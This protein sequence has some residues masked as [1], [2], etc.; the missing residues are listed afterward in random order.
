LNINGV[1]KKRKTREI[2]IDLTHFGNI[3]EATQART[4]SDEERKVLRDAQEV[5]ARLVPNPNN[6]TSAAVLGGQEDPESREPK[7]G[8]PG[9]RS[10][11]DFV[12]PDVVENKHRELKAGQVCP[13]GCGRLYALKRPLHHR[14][15]TGQA[16][17]K[18]TLFESEQL[19]CSTCGTVYTAPLPDGVGPDSYAPSAKSTIAYAKYGLG[20]PF[21]RQAMQYAALGVPISASVLWEAVSSA[22]DV[23]QPVYEHL[24]Q[25]AAEGEVGFFDD[26]SMPILNFDRKANDTRTGLFTTGIVSTRG[27]V[28]V[29][30]FVTGRDHAGEN[31]ATLLAKRPPELA[32]MIQMSDA[33][34]ANTAYVSSD[35]L[36]AFCLAHG[37]R[38]FVKIIE[39]FPAEC[40]HVIRTIGTVYHHDSLSREAGHTPEERL[41][42]H[43][44]L[45]G[46]VMDTLKFWLDGQ[47]AARKTEPNSNLGKAI[48]YLRKH[49]EGLTLFLRQPGA[50]LDSNAVE[51]ILKKVVLFRKNSLFYKTAR[52]ARV[53]DIYLSLI[54]T[55][56]L[57]RANPHQY[58]TVLQHHIEAFKAAPADWMPWNFR[59]A[60]DRIRDPAATT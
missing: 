36:I 39:S 14:H 26:T 58:L 30:I 5:L 32:K 50:P 46:P 53:G 23:L 1:G 18:V 45:S 37:R 28:Q 11:S 10:R 13:C 15:F 27:D 38:N 25:V 41:A 22:A 24:M 16:A 59:E 43:K 49:W 47:I 21:H 52:G 3:V 20:T 56:Q 7:K 48:E 55:C 34:A 42:F 51:R 12:D 6:E 31:R 35:E 9:R 4:L 57:N 29:A 33:L 40:R 19:R 54:A 8:G 44:E 60:L 17:L 2:G